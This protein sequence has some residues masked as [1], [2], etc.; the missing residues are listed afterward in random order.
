MKNEIIRAVLFIAIPMGLVQIIYRLFDN[1][2]N[3]TK[4]F[5]DKH[6]VLKKNRTFIR[7]ISTIAVI[8]VLGVIY[9]ILSQFYNV[10]REIFY[11]AVGALAGLINGIT[12]SIAYMDYK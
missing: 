5:C 12:I 6:P 9:M 8:L 4:T 11:I 3:R 10:P 1:K 2:F 7:A